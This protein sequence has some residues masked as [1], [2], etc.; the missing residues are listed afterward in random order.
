MW[1][2]YITSV[3]Y[4]AMVRPGGFSPPGAHRT[5]SRWLNKS[6]N[7]GNV[8]HKQWGIAETVKKCNGEL[9]IKLAAIAVAVTLVVKQWGKAHWNADMCLYLH[10]HWEPI[11]LRNPNALCKSRWMLC[12][13]CSSSYRG[14]CFQFVPLVRHQ[15]AYFDTLS[16][17][18]RK[19]NSANAFWTGYLE[20]AMGSCFR[21]VQKSAQMSYMAVFIIVPPKQWDGQIC[22]RLIFTVEPARWRR[23]CER[24]NSTNSNPNS[25]IHDMA[26]NSYRYFNIVVLYQHLT[27]CTINYYC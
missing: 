27:G 21:I 2:N 22:Q 6:P 20:T 12:I 14:A 24:P 4:W 10:S 19:C 11:R 15:S 26:P 5:S 18:Y 9:G 8:S 17:I 1:L 23:T 3:R 25:F 7:L 13:F 16:G